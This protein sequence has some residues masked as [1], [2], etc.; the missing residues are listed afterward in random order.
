MAKT[1]QKPDDQM[2]G[3]ALVLLFYFVI[4]LSTLFCLF[5]QVLTYEQT[6]F[7]I[8]A[9]QTSGLDYWS[10]KAA[11]YPTQQRSKHVKSSECLGRIAI[12]WLV[13]LNSI[14]CQVDC[15][16]KGLILLFS[17]LVESRSR[18]LF[19]LLSVFHRMWFSC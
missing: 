14:W 16:Q 6:R 3:L 5:F 9:W 2:K 12:K 10:L 1:L 17:R 4:L 11:A 15:K 18:T 19:S 13:E 7:F 8:G